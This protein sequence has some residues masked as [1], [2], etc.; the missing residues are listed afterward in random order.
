[1]HRIM[2]VEDDSL[3]QRLYVDILQ[4]EGFEVLLRSTGGDG[5]RA[6]PLDKPD[7]IL[8]DVNLPDGNGIDFC[9]SL[10]AD[11]LTR[12][13]PVVIV[14]GE[15]RE[16]SNRVAGLDGGAEDYLFKPVDP[17]VLV[18]RIRSLLKLAVKPS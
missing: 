9:R 1:M 10:K 6:A 15:A 8:L 5:L 4:R 18:A 11:K 3:L 16:L 12:H 7:L 17:K 2:V 14:T 13:I